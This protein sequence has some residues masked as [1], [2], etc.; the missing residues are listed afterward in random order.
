MPTPPPLPGRITAG[1][2]TDIT[3]TPT[4]PTSTRT[5]STSTRT[6][7]SRAPTG[8]IGTRAASTAIATTRIAG[9]ATGLTLPVTAARLPGRASSPTGTVTGRAHGTFIRS[10]IRA[11]TTVTEPDF[12][13]PAIAARPSSAFRSLSG[14]SL[15]G[16]GE[17]LTG[18][19]VRARRFVFPCDI[20]LS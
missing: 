2:P 10:T 18:N 16:S 17:R 6:G 15:G 4:G 19:F 1:T 20:S 13:P 5:G 8:I 11:P 12:A 9:T 3:G 7:S 14:P